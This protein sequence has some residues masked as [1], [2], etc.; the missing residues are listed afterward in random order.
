MVSAISARLRHASFVKGSQRLPFHDCA[1]GRFTPIASQRSARWR[2]EPPSKA[3]SC[4]LPS[5]SRTTGASIVGA[6]VGGTATADQSFCGPP[7]AR[8]NATPALTRTHNDSRSV[9]APPGRL[10]PELLSDPL[11]GVVRGA[12][13]AALRRLAAMRGQGRGGAPAGG[14]QSRPLS[15]WLSNGSP[16]SR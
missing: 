11:R 4:R 8:D 1:L 10:L 15:G 2:S 16:C 14:A 3:S 13:V 9:G 7:S 12:F 6:E 5:I